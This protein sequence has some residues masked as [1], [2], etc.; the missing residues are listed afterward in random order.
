MK[1]IRIRSNLSRIT[2]YNRA[3][4]CKKKKEKSVEKFILNFYVLSF[5]FFL[6]FLFLFYFFSLSK[7]PFPVD[8][9]LR[10]RE[11][12]S[13]RNHR[14]V[15]ERDKFESLISCTNSYQIWTSL[16]QKDDSNLFGIVSSTGTGSNGSFPN[17]VFD[18]GGIIS[19]ARDRIPPRVTTKH[20]RI[21]TG[22]EETVHEDQV[23][24]FFFFPKKLD[25]YI[26]IISDN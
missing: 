13:A 4:D 9:I 23:Y 11:S 15:F 14:P 25:R 6:S 18:S 21:Y 12:T 3:Y 17:C 16:F 5:L 24:S 26:T 10:R 2:R 7:E 8:P 1:S 20:V 22:I 19:W